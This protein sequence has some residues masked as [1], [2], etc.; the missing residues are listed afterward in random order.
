MSLFKT[1]HCQRAFEGGHAAKQRGGSE[2]S[3]DEVPVMGMERRFLNHPAFKLINQNIWEKLMEKA[4][5]F[6]EIGNSSNSW[7][8]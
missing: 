8:M 7:M 1:V 4:K 6:K 5:S 2:R 3:N